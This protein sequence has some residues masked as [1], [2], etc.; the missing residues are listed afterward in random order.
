M[1][2]QVVVLAGGTSKKLVPLVSK[3]FLSP[4]FYFHSSKQTKSYLS[5]IS[6][7]FSRLPNT[8]LLYNTIV[9]FFFL[10]LFYSLGFL[11][12]CCQE[13]PKAL[14][15]VA[16]RP[17]L[18][19]VLELLELSNLKD[20]IVVRILL[21]APFVSLI[22][23]NFCF[24]FVSMIKH[25]VDYNFCWLNLGGD[26]SG[27]AAKTLRITVGFALYILFCRWWKGKMQLFLLA[28]GYQ[29]LMRIG[30]MLRYLAS[31]SPY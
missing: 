4:L 24:S 31:C 16:N 3:V 13:V 8:P 29:E 20:L 5:F 11:L 30:Y 2:F 10:C 27:L 6:F 12:F 21:L 15:P 14:L 26:F 18:S 17:V 25:F 23:L 7:E 28:V 19:Y 22:A 1:D 9:T